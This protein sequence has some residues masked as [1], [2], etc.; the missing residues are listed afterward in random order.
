MLIKHG[1]YIKVQ[2]KDNF[3]I[4]DAN[5]IKTKYK[6]GR[7]QTGWLN[8]NTNYKFLLLQMQ[9]MNTYAKHISI[10]Y[11]SIQMWA[12]TYWLPLCLCQVRDTL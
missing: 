11:I 2:L 10:E 3:L 12:P 8:Q 7:G 4:E 1:T 6:V 5:N 9:Y